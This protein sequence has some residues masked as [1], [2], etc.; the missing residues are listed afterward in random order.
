MIC[1]QNKTDFKKMRVD[2][3]ESFFAKNKRNFPNCNVDFGL[4]PVKRFVIVMMLY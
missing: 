2:Q 3:Y 1:N 4:S